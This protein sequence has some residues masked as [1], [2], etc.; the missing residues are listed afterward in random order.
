[1]CLYSAII[2][3]L[4]AA[5]VKDPVPSFT[6]PIV[7]FCKS[8]K[9]FLPSEYFTGTLPPVW[10]QQ[11][12]TVGSSQRL[13]ARELRFYQNCS[14]SAISERAGYVHDVHTRSCDDVHE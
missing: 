4:P 7:Y 3:N 10:Q 13:I 9:C 12:K 6:A 8:E 2:F 5:R 14:I 11:W 1:M